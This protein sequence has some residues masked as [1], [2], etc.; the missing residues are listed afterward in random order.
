VRIVARR[1]AGDRRRSHRR[2]R[3]LALAAIGLATALAGCAAA[4][5]GPAVTFPAVSIGPDRTVG[6]AVSL[7]RSELVKALGDRRVTMGDATVPFRPAEAPMLTEAP[8]AVYQAIL[9][10]DPD[11]GF[12]VVYELPDPDRADQAAREQAAYLAT[13]PG[14]IQRSL[15]SVDV[16][17]VLGST[18]VLYTWIPSEAKDGQAPDVQ[19]ALETLGYGVAVPS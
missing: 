2:P 18:V 13:G 9:P 1:P 14:R 12:I 6:P 8:R 3:L 5:D 19:A 4:T 15:E 17:R 16:I 11:K 10:A 7:T